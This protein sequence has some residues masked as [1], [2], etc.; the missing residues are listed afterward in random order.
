M[1]KSEHRWYSVNTTY[2]IGYNFEKSSRD[3]NSYWVSGPGSLDPNGDWFSPGEPLA[4]ASLPAWL[5]R[6]EVDTFLC[7][8]VSS[9]PSLPTPFTLCLLRSRSCL[10]WAVP[11]R[12]VVS[13]S[14]TPE[15]VARQAALSVGILQARTLGGLPCLL[16]GPI[17]FSPNLTPPFTLREFFSWASP[18][19]TAAPS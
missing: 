2:F 18:P 7:T 5:G 16:L 9:T 10:R 12:S 14:E 8:P 15:T 3:R 17:Y 1:G 19:H 11:S 13:D 4:P 6:E